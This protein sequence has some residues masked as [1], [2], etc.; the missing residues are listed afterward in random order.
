MSVIVK[1]HWSGRIVLYSKGADSSIFSHLANFAGIGTSTSE[2]GVNVHVDNGHVGEGENGG[3]GEGG[4]E[5]E[6]GG[7]GV[8]GGLGEG[9]RG[10][11]GGGEITRQLTEQ[12]LTLYA[13]QGLRTLCMAKRVS[14]TTH[15]LSL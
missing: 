1:E 5:V 12:H 13:R 10:G 7:E 9:G 2:T 6:G 15:P 8:S 14:F 4:E 3:E 11:V